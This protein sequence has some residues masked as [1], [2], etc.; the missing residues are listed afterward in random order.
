[1]RP[2]NQ[3]TAW[4]AAS[5][6]AAVSTTSVHR[7]AGIVHLAGDAF[8]LRRVDHHAVADDRGRTVVI[9]GRD[10]EDDHLLLRTACR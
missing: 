5:A 6:C 4:P 10:A 1:M 3:P 9:V 8:L 7:K 2:W